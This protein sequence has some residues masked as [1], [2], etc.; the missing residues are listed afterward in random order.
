MHFQRSLRG[1]GNSLTLAA[2]TSFDGLPV[3]MTHRNMVSLCI[4][5]VKSYLDFFKAYASKYHKYILNF[6]FLHVFE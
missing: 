5:F 1:E 4:S 3:L 2:L 6:H